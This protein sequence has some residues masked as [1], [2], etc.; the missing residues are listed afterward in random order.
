MPK[1]TYH[2]YECNKAYLF[3]NDYNNDK[4]KNGIFMSCITIMGS[5]KLFVYYER[6]RSSQKIRKID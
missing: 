3:E 4:N 2:N 5:C 1:N 6:I